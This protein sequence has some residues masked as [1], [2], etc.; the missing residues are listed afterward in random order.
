MPQSLLLLLDVADH[1]LAVFD[2]KQKGLSSVISNKSMWSKDM[3]KIHVIF[4]MFLTKLSADSRVDGIVD[5]WKEYIGFK[6]II[7]TKCQHLRPP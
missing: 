5:A 6:C 1:F 3:N 2:C 7:H 4:Y